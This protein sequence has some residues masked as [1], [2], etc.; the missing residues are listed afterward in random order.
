V[1]TPP[2]RKPPNRDA[3]ARFDTLC[4]DCR[5]ISHAR[6]AKTRDLRAKTRDLR[7]ISHAPYTMMHD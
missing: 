3:F 7:T 4:H 5:T 6:R 1:G 2:R